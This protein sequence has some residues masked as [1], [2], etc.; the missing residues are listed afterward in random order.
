MIA[1][2]GMGADR[3][4]AFPDKILLSGGGF[5]VAAPPEVSG[6]EK[7]HRAARGG[8]PLRSLDVVQP[9]IQQAQD[10]DGTSSILLDTRMFTA[11]EIRLDP[12]RITITVEEVYGL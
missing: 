2:H 1:K 8:R 11:G 10:G 7:S 9:A 6:G 4:I 3:T 12:P 5:V